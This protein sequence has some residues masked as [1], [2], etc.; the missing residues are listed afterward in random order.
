[1]HHLRRLPIEKSGD[2]TLFRDRRQRR[3]KVLNER[4]GNPLLPACTV[5]VG[6]TQAAKGITQGQIEQETIVELMCDSKDVQL[7]RSER[8][9]I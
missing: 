3:A 7:R 2:S 8:D 6:R 1:M 5:H 4:L 9:P